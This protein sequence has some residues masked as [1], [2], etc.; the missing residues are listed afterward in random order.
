M[1]AGIGE[2]VT[3]LYGKREGDRAFFAEDVDEVN[4]SDPGPGPVPFMCMQRAGI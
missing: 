4:L 2:K 1:R 3:E